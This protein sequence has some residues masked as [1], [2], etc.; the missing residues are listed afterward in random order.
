M[1]LTN[2]KEELLM[3]TVELQGT[4]LCCEILPSKLSEGWDRVRLRLHVKNEYLDYQD[5]HRTILLQDME[6]WITAMHR[7]I[8]GAYAKEYNLVFENAGLAIDLYPYQNKDGKA[9]RVERRENDSVMAMRI[10]MRSSDKRTFLGGVYTLIFHKAELAA[11]AKGLRQEF[12]RAYSGLLKGSGE[13]SFVG[14]SPLGCEGCSYWYLD[15]SK[16]VKQGDYVWV[17][18]GKHR[19]EQIVLVDQIRLFTEENAPYDP[20]RVKRILRLATAEEVE[21]AKISLR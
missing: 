7:L 2:D 9:S 21:N 17:C 5:V 20:K 14:V 16:A 4:A 3:P 12:Y 10:L 19:L 15:E 13:L 8:A 6:E 18:M 11:F 1:P